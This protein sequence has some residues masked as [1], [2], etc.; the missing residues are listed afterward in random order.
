MSG[1][2][3]SGFLFIYAHISLDL[4]SLGSAEAYIVWRGKLNNHLMA[5]RVGNIRTKYYQNLIIVFQVTVK[6]VGDVFLR[7]SVRTEMVYL[8]AHPSK[9]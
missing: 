6:N 5:S 3:L 7:Y 1:M 8:S 4:L 9:Y 2:F